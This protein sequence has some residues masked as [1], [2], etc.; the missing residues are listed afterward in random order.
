[1]VVTTFKTKTMKQAK[2]ILGA[3]IILFVCGGFLYQTKHVKK[4]VSTDTVYYY[5]HQELNIKLKR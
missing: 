2:I 3:I 1:M 4:E 5:V